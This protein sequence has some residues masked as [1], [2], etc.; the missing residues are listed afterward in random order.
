MSLPA[1]TKPRPQP[2]RIGTAVMTF[3]RIFL[4]VAMMP[5]AINKIFDYQFQVSAWLYAQQLNNVPGRMLTWAMMGYAP[6]FQ[7]LLGL[8]EFIPA[9]LLFLARTRRLGALLM[10]P[11]V[12]NVFLIN[13]YLDLWPAT[14]I[15]SGVLLA[16]NVFLLLYDLPMYLGFAATLLAA[17]T[18]IANPKLRLTAKIA[19]FLVPAAIIVAFCIYDYNGIQQDGVAVSD[20]IGTRQINGAGT[21]KIVSINVAGQPVP[22][23]PHTRFFFDF[24]KAAVFGEVQHF[25]KGTFAANKL[26]GTFEIDK[27][28]LAGSAAPI[29]GTYKAQDK[30]L[31]LT[32]T[33]D[34][35]PVVIVLEQDNWGRML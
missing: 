6:H 21:W 12:L 30:R 19:G 32:A 24:T 9:V 27:V 26:K 11:V 10:F 28:Q 17:P 20:F 22:I 7:V 14:Q 33:R 23:D 8:L 5:Y 15:I 34:N 25:S 3:A 16:I 18:P 35:Q 31:L 4:G 1:D 13:I 2:S 29:V